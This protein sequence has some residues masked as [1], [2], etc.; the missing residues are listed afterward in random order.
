MKA[1]IFYKSHLGSTKTYAYWIQKQLKCDIF[2]FRQFK[3]AKIEKYDTVIVCSGTY[4]GKMPM[5]NFLIKTWPRIKDKNVVAIAVGVVSAH[6]D[7]SIK[8]YNR[9]PAN[10]RR[11]IKYFKIPGKI[12][13]NK[14]LGEV[15]PQNLKLI[16]EYL[17]K[18]R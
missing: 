14:P 10:I 4:I 9:I 5:V 13:D 12:G 2:L 17:K 7:A 16:F 8:S 6:D 3:K 15:R 11:D 1:V 18:L